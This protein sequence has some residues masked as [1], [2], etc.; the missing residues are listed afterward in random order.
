VP[1]VQGFERDP[2]GDPQKFVNAV[3]MGPTPAQSIIA[4]HSSVRQAEM[5]RQV[6]VGPSIREAILFQIHA[7]FVSLMLTCVKRVGVTVVSEFIIVA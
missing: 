6:V 5:T 2:V 4:R 3:G 1:A 7:L